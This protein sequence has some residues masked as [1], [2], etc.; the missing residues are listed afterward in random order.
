MR[1]RDW[2]IITK[3][4]SEIRIAYPLAIYRRSMVNC[5]E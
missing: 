3:L 1:H 5:H 4:L 2:V